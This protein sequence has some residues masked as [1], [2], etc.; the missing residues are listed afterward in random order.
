MN[1]NIKINVKK[2]L[3]LLNTGVILLTGCSKYTIKIEKE[4]SE[5]TTEYT[6]EEITTEIITEELTTEA[7]TE[8]ITIEVTTESSKEEEIIDMFDQMDSE[9]NE[10][11]S[12]ENI[13]AC[14][15]EIG[16]YVATMIGF[17]WYGEEI[18]GITYDEL[19]ESAKEEVK[20]IYFKVDSSIE[21]KIPNYKETI[22]DKYTV[23]ASFLKEKG[24]YLK[25][26]SEDYIKEK[27][28]EDNYN[29][30]IDMQKDDF[31]DVKD[32]LNETKEDATK[33]VDEWYKEK[34]KSK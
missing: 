6:T 32:F 25:D 13:E 3:L 5:L 27:V 23:V 8:E 30:F 21:S 10:L 24:T 26:K 2:T 28:G 34:T 17:I 29:E 22:K 7:K 16:D 1:H 19:S 15:S 12:E 31:N 4:E 33:K 18:N 20:E 14:M 11:L 9:I